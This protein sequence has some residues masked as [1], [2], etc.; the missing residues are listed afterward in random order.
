MDR[1]DELNQILKNIVPIDAT[2]LEEGKNYCDRLAKPLGALGKM[3]KMYARLHAMFPDNI[4]LTKKMVMIYVADNGVCDEGISSNPIE[5]TFIVANNI[6]NGK[7][8]VANIAEYAGSDIC[9]I[10]IG[11][12]SPIYPDNPDHILNGTR[13]ML[14]EPA[15]TRQEALE[16]ILV[17]YRRTVELINQGYTLF[18]TGE[19]GVGNTTTSAAVIAATLGLPA[20]EVTG[21]GAGVTEKM[22]AH[23]TAVIQ[24]AVTNH[25]PYSD[26]IDLVSKVGGQLMLGTC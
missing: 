12:K 23:K 24:E 7:A 18:G 2:A 13:N 20:Q 5:T 21:Y 3:E 10:D 8:G 4:Q 14:K 6:R 11:C 19:M 25:A 15:M 17:G 1:Q 16:A 9:V 26:M 22:K